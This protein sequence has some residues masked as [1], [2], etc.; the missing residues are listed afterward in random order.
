M[1]AVSVSD[2]GDTQVRSLKRQLARVTEERDLLK[3]HLVEG[4][5]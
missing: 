3:N 1:T 4:F 5:A 2:D